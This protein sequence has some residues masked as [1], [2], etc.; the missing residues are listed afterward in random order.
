MDGAALIGAG[1]G[2]GLGGNAMVR[3]ALSTQ[4]NHTVK[5]QWKV[6]LGATGYVRPTQEVEHATLAISEIMV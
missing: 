6:S 4:G 1:H 2:E 5:L 3:R